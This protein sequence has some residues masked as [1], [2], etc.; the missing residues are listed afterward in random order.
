M[1]S[2]AGS[3]PASAGRGPHPDNAMILIITSKQ[4]SHVG[5][6]ARYFDDAG[7][8]WVRL[9][10]EDFASNVELTVFPAQGHGTIL[11]RDSGRV[12]HLQDVRAVWYRKPDPVNVA[13]FAACEPAALDYIEAEFTE[14]ILGLYSLLRHAT[15]IN[16]PFTTRIAHRKMLQLSVAASVGFAT[17]QTVITNNPETALAFARGLS[18]DVAIKSL[19]S[20]AV[21][22]PS[23]DGGAIQYGLFTRRVSL[24][25][26]E[27]VKESIRH[28][29]TSFQEFIEKQYELRITCVG[30]RCFACRIESRTGDLTADDYR[31]DT[32]GL[33][34]VPQKCQ[35]LEE[36]LQSYL[37]TFGLNFGCFDIL[38]TK[39]G[40]PVF[41][42]CNPNGQW[43]WVENMTGL[44]IGQA[45][46][47]ELMSAHEG[48]VGQGHLEIETTPL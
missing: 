14:I 38:I 39:T 16:D 13:H 43:L 26:L 1:T 4:D 6:V 25:E 27:S 3:R 37:K 21:T 7:V 10:T 12:V 5:A 22:T 30:A 45:I 9:N 33:I 42:E 2:P 36:K 8:P 35:E 41:L 46:A 47:Q 44:P 40:E 28:Q 31:F 48:V 32:T 19:G 15:W 34:H 20:I 29:P 17:P 11:V 18:G 23:E 24:A